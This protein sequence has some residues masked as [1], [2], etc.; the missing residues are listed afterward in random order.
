M[1][2][3]RSIISLFDFVLKPPIDK[4]YKNPHNACNAADTCNNKRP[5]H[6]PCNGNV[7]I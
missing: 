2:F 6:P 5:D 3:G 1:K 7:D 4:T